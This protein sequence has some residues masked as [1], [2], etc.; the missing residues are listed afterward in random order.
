MALEALSVALVSIARLSRECGEVRPLATRRRLHSVRHVPHRD[1]IFPRSVMHPRLER[2][3]VVGV[4]PF[5]KAGHSPV[6]SIARVDV[7]LPRVRT[8]RTVGPSR[9]H[10]RHLVIMRID[11]PRK[12]GK[13]RG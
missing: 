8:H 3:R 4:S 6:R 12:V 5:G 11:I 1:Y 10:A 13:P 7:T 9:C 2:C